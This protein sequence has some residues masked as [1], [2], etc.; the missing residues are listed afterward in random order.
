MVAS[1]VGST[2]SI[3]DHQEREDDVDR[4]W[5]LPTVFDEDGAVGAPFHWSHGSDDLNMSD[6][7]LLGGGHLEVGKGGDVFELFH[8]SQPVLEEV[9]LAG[10]CEPT[11]PEYGHVQGVPDLQTRLAGLH[12]DQG[13]FSLGLLFVMF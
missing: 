8:P 12:L 1:P 6:G 2:N 9:G 10:L 13:K 11:P 7:L 5:L 4:M 3:G